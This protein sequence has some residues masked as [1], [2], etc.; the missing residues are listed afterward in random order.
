MNRCFALALFLLAALSPTAAQADKRPNIVFIISDD[1]RWD[2]L[3]AA[4]NT[5]IHT[6]VLDRLARE[7]VYFRQATV[8]IPQCAPNRATLLTGLPP[9]RHGYYSNQVQR[10]DVQTPNGFKKTPLLPGLLRDA[11]YRT[12][13]VGK[14][15]V[16][17]DPWNCGFSDV[18]TW[19]PGGS[20]RYRDVPLAHGNTRGRTVEAGFTNQVF[21]NNAVAFLNSGEAKQKPFF[22]WLALTAPHLPMGPNPPRIQKLYANKTEAD[23]L[24]PGFPKDTPAKGGNWIRYYEAISHLDEQTGRVLDALAAQKLAD[25]TVVVFVGDNGYMMGSRGLNGKVVPYDESV[26]VPLL[27]RAPM[28]TRAASG[29]GPKGATDA[30]V[31]SLDLPPTFLRLAGVT[32]PK[33]F[34]EAVACVC[35]VFGPLQQST[36]QRPQA[37]LVQRWPNRMFAGSRFRSVLR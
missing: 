17:P 33:E 8:H 15:H 19:L 7:G 31:S 1:Q 23:L 13:L 24:P 16:K 25:N 12:V 28:M 9:H 3:G 22:L 32:P 37:G 18:R 4:G 6:P 5:A 2:T 21:A 11:G 10:P 20:A 14:W 36:R 30:P 27:V 35:V 34:T 29:G 26:R